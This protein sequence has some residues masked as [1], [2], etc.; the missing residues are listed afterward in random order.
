MSDNKNKKPDDKRTATQKLADLEG[1]TMS[2]FS[3]TDNLSRDLAMIRDAIKLLDNKLNAIVKA[4][5]GSEALTDEVISRIMI[6]NNA[7]E[8]KAKVDK[9]VT[10]GILVAETIV[11]ENAFVIGKESDESGTVVNPRLQFA[12]KA[13]PAEL[14]AKIVGAE[15]GT[16][17][18]V[19]PG[20][21]KLTV[22]ESYKIQY[23][24]AAAPE[25][26]SEPAPTPA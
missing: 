13:L 22:T 19:E 2:L 6:Q 11:S 25:V 16:T 20:K 3:V 9:M 15:V 5:R 21:L 24:E 8:L 18:D 14:Q 7:D 10:E 12:L 23:P 1:A 17:L 4:T 26:A